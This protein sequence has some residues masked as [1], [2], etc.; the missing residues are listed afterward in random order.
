ME[1][2][3][4]CAVCNHPP[5]GPDARYGCAFGPSKEITA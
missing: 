3:N 4:D 1:G 5:R 2:L